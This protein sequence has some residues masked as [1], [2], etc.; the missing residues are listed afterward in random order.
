[1]TEADP[2]RRLAAD[3]DLVYADWDRAVATV[4]AFMTGH[5]PV[6]TGTLLD[7]HCATGL[8]ADAAARLGWRVT[9]ADPSP[10]MLE[11]V[12]ARLPDV[13]L[14]RA[15]PLTLA[16]DAP[17]SYDAVVSVGNTLASFREDGVRTALEQL[18]R[19]TRDGGACMIAV[20]DFSERLKSAVWRDDPLARVAARFRYQDGGE[21][22]YTLD[23]DDADGT[24]SHDQVLY[25]LS[26]LVLTDALEHAGFGVRRCSRT[27]GRL[28]VG[29]VAA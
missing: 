22:L 6:Q 11:R 23:L 3:Y 5:L 21:I 8:A 10:A 4:Q 1:M 19:C 14:V 27:A 7:A 28:V 2:D 16:D 13:T 26:E 12:A 15:A 24:R 18:R 25:P 9:A 29:A 17:G 20:R